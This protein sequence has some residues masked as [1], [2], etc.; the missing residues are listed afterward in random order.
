MKEKMRSLICTY[1]YTWE[2]TLEYIRVKGGK[3]GSGMSLIFTYYIRSNS[4]PSDIDWVQD[5]VR[6]KFAFPGICWSKSYI[7]LPVWR[8]GASN[9]NIIEGLHADVN[10]EGVACTL[11]GGMKKGLHYDTMKL[12]TLNVS[13]MLYILHSQSSR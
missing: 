3:A 9:S 8:V 11:V 4:L 10:R 13:L 5:K 2:D 6:S 12:R 7:P 1:H